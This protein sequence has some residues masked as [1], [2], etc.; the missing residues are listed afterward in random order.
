MELYQRAVNTI[1]K[2]VLNDTVVYAIKELTSKPGYTS[3][4]T[5]HKISYTIHERYDETVS[6]SVEFKI[7]SDSYIEF[8]VQNVK[9]YGGI[10]ET[11]VR[12]NEFINKNKS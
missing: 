8:C 1:L 2:E 6:I 12:I 9:E 5:A 4:E 3:I 7:D 11:I 10:L